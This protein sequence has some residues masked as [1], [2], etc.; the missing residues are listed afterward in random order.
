MTYDGLLAA[1]QDYLRLE[2]IL[3][4]SIGVESFLVMYRMNCHLQQRCR[5]MGAM[6]AAAGPAD[7]RGVTRRFWA[8]AQQILGSRPK[9][10]GSRPKWISLVQ[11]Y[12]GSTGVGTCPNSSGRMP[13]KC[14]QAATTSARPSFQHARFFKKVL[15]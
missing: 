13:K 3:S 5:C 9:I 14:M 1:V 15:R 4:S 6:M 11:G 12:V 8:P 7:D 2:V 10:L